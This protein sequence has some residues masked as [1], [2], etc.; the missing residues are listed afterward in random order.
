MKGQAVKQRARLTDKQPKIYQLRFRLAEQH[1][2]E[3]YFSDPEM[4]EQYYLHLTALGVIGGRVI[5][6]AESHQVDPG[7]GVEPWSL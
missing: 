7:H 6:A 5:K 3:M 2:A 1:W 4:A